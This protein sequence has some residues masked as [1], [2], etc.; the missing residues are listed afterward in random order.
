MGQRTDILTF[1]KKILFFDMYQTL[2]DTQIGDKKEIEENAHKTV[3]VDFLVR[4]NIEENAANA[5]QASY[6]KLRDE[7]YVHHD[8][9]IEHHDFKKILGQTFKNLYNLEVN[10]GVLLDLIW[11]YRIL[12]R[13]E[14]K[15]YPG[16]KETLETLSKEYRMFLASYTQACYSLLELKEFGVKGYFEGFI[17][18]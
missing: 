16:I 15:L 10:D 5:F 9:K 3:F 14:T 8:K 1:M 12:V 17:R 11:Q 6:E 18:A 2:V 13:G 7:F 4:N